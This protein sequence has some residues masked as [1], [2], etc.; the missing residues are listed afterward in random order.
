[1]VAQER[2]QR[3]KARHRTKGLEAVRSV[4]VLMN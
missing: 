2:A 3:A 1:M 4:S